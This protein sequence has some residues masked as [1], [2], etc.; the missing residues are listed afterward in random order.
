MM[1]STGME[2]NSGKLTRP[3]RLRFGAFCEDDEHIRALDRVKAW[4]RE[5]LELAVDDTVLVS[6]V[7]CALPGCPPLKTVVTFWL[8]GTTR[9]W[10]TIFKGVAD[11][12]LDDLPPAW[13]KP[14]LC[15]SERSEYECC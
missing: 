3:A 11:V 6:E 7:R 2:H 10:F 15:S 1:A 13:L 4:T 9:H 14:A 12:I 5:C 8:D